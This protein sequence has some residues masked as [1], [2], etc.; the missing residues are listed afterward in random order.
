M[1]FTTEGFSEA[2]IE[3]VWP[4]WDLNPR[5]LNF[6]QTLKPTELS[7]HEFIMSNLSHDHH[8]A[9]DKGG[10]L[11]HPM[12]IKALLLVQPKGYLKPRN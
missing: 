2:A 9:T 3:K 10:S 11:V 7:G 4:E 5:P 8:W 1:V 12:F 6:I